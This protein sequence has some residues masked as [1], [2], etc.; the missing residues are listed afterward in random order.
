MPGRLV[1][2]LE[3]VRHGFRKVNYANL[4]YWEVNHNYDFWFN[5]KYKAAKNEEVQNIQS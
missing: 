2:N 4:D 5:P 1:K 3:Y